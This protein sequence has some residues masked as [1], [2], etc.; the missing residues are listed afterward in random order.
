M[1]NLLGNSVCIIDQNAFFCKLEFACR[2]LYYG[3]MRILIEMR[4]PLIRL[5]Q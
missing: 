5:D 2:S 3:I 4:R 1:E